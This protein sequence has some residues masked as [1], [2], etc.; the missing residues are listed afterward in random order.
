MIELD[1]CIKNNKNVYIKLNENGTPITCVESMK[2][3]FEYS[4]AMNIIGC[5]PKT[6]KRLKRYLT[7]NQK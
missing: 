2:G 5:L 6:L 4:K 7:F 1:Y 3:V